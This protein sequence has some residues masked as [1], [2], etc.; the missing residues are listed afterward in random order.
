MRVLL[1]GARS[2]L[3]YDIL[4]LW[5][6][7][8]I[9]PLGHSACD[10]TDTAAVGAAV[11]AARPDL[12]INLAASHRVDAVESDPTEALHV[13]ALGAWEV[14]R[15][16]AGAG[17][18]VMWVSTD[19]VF[20]G[21][22]GSPY[23]EDDP[24]DPI[25]AYGVSKAAGERLVALANP[26]HY[27]IRTSGLYGVA[28]AS[29]KGGNF[30]ETMLRLARAGNALRVVNDQI[31]GPTSTSDLATA[32]RALAAS[33]AYG[34][35]HIT[36]SGAISWYDF[37]ALIFQLCGVAADLTPVS[38]ADYGAPAR[39]PAY[40]VLANARTAALGLAPLRPIADALRAYLMEKRYL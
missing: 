35:Y 12:V 16:A 34:L 27:I 9:T 8:Q 4:R 19:Y 28:G 26:R 14:A 3:G 13:N 11:A 39:R 40:S 30:V 24:T 2:Q 1:L 21:D 32:M 23:L 25:N 38:S 36:N 33:E 37:A 18:A 29:G 31:L 17:A 7:D 6:G 5:T 22:K 10:V 20:S 15:A